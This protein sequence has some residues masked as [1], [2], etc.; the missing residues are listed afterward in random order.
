MFVNF[1]RLCILTLNLTIFPY[2]LFKAYERYKGFSKSSAIIN[3]ALFPMLILQASLWYVYAWATDEWFMIFTN[4]VNA[5]CNICIWY[6]IRNH[7]NV[8]TVR[9]GADGIHTHTPSNPA[10]STHEMPSVRHAQHRFDEN[11]QSSHYSQATHPHKYTGDWQFQNPYRS[12]QRDDSAH[13]N[14]I[15][16]Q[17]YKPHHYAMAPG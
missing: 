12:V 5:S 1:V 2:Q 4:T 15:A 10:S 14:F 16:T 11:M 17:P 3:E 9:I 13:Y 8:D 7:K 6:C